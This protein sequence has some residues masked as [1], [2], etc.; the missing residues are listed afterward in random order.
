LKYLSPYTVR[1]VILLF[2]PSAQ[3]FQKCTSTK[4]N[5]VSQKGFDRIRYSM[6]VKKGA[7]GKRKEGCPKFKDT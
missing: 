2:L 7:L 5:W 1:N 3:S 6:P 4:Y